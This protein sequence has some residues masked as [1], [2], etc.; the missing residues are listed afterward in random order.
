MH[1]GELASSLTHQLLA[2]S[3]QQILEPKV[4]DLNTVVADTQK[5]L[6]RLI[7]EHVHLATA[8]QP[9]LSFVKV[10]PGQIGQVIINLA[11]NARDSM[12]Q[13]GILTIETSEAELAEQDAG[14]SPQA[15]TRRFVVMAIS[16]T[17]CGMTPETKARIFEPFFTTKDVGKGTGL[18]L[19]VVLGIVKQS[20]GD[21]QVYS[22][23]GLGTTIRIYLPVTEG[24]PARLPSKAPELKLEGFETI[25]LVEDDEGVRKFGVQALER[26]GYT[27]RSVSG[28]EAALRFMAGHDTRIDLLVT[29]VVMLGMGGP[30]LAETLKSRYPDMK[31]LFLSGYTD[32]TIVLHGIL[33]ANVSFLQKPFTSASL[34]RKVREVLDAVVLDAVR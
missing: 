13:G 25:L 19:A 11:I 31:V 22:E 27:V 14:K 9:N 30:K 12:P 32:D 16:D 33:Q 8:L 21:I 4:L 1:A 20:G 2:F 18:G 10:D 26:Y 29:D 24:G 23:I 17:G 28:G 5:M 7:G 34:A 15:E 3:R 6:R